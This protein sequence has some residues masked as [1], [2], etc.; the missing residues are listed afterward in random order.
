[1]CC[2]WCEK[3]GLSIRTSDAKK[4]EVKK[5]EK[6]T[7]ENWDASSDLQPEKMPTEIVD[8]LLARQDEK[9]KKKDKKERN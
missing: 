5:R 9:K 6:E 7:G 2:W 8:F 4:R 3:G 1:M